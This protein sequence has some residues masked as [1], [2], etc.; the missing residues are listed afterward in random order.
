MIKYLWK[1]KLLFIIV[2]LSTFLFSFYL[3]FISYFL[4]NIVDLLLV[5][6]DINISSVIT[7]FIIIIVGYMFLTFIAN[8]SKYKLEI[9]IQKRIELDIAD[10]LLNQC[11]NVSE[12]LNIFNKEINLV[13][14]NYLSI[15]ISVLFSAFTFLFAFIYGLFISWQII[16][17]ITVL[18]IIM[19]TINQLFAD[20]IASTLQNVQEE[21]TNVNKIVNGIFSSIRTINIFIANKFAMDKL[22]LA[23]DLKKEASLKFNKINIHLSLINGCIS[24]TIQFGALITAFVFV[25]YN[26]MTV[27]EVIALTT[28]FQYIT[29]PLSNLMKYKNNIDSTKNIRNKLSQIL[30][31]KYDLFIEPIEDNNIIFDNVNF[32]YTEEQFI[33]DMNLK[34][35]QNKKYLVV[36]KSGSGKSTLL[37]LILKELK[38]TSG[39]ITYGETNLENFNNQ[40]W[41]KKISYCSQKIEIIPGTLLENIIL[42]DTN[43]EKKLQQICNIIDFKSLISKLNT[44]LSEDF[45]NF[46]GGELQRVAI[47][48]MLYKDSAILIFDEFTSALDNLTAYQIEKEILQITNKL[49]INVT[50]RI[51]LSLIEQ[52]EKIIILENGKVKCIGNYAEIA[53]ELAPYITNQNL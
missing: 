22:N 32:K 17:S 24:Y 11:L 26:F 27:G 28:M 12:V 30:S 38:P 1:Y 5:G 31:E 9:K 41:Y 53:D 10:K 40:T 6:K 37:K 39:N 50:H 18:V 16:L 21:N 44:S 14:E 33:E 8:T 48:R 36:G 25:H 49:I 45:S 3:I 29:N 13:V 20:K 47:A 7:R 2:L 51:Q 4:S 46:S 19:I 23:F 52:Y 42:S 43:D 15:F 35:I 34:F